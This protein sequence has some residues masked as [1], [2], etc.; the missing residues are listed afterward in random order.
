MATHDDAVDIFQRNDL[1]QDPALCDLVLVQG[2]VHLDPSHQ[3]RDPVVVG[4]GRQIDGLSILKP[5]LQPQRQTA[6]VL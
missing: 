2:L 5:D 6:R 4:D 1:L 3:V